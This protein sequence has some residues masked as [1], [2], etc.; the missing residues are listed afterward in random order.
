MLFK[1]IKTF[2]RKITKNLLS[3][4]GAT[5][6]PTSLDSY[7]TKNSGDT[8]SEA[9]INNVQDAIEALETKIGKDSSAIATAI[10]YFLKHVSGNFRIHVHAGGINDGANIPFANITG[11]VRDY[12][13]LKDVKVAATPGGTFTKDTWQQRNINTEEIDTGDN[14]SV[15]SNQITLDAGTYECLIKCPAYRVD[16]H[17]ARLRNITDNST[18]LEG[19]GEF[20]VDSADYVQTSSFIMG[21]F[22][23]AAGKA[24]EIQHYCSTGRANDGLGVPVSFVNEVY[25]I[26]EFRKVA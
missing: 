1:K 12:I 8:I 11:F 3:E 17:K 13:L 18:T 21:R 4:V 15:A 7:S 6:F 24:F 19:T 16:N 26:A 25:T 14:C 2:I 9:H 23:I 10:D 22:T 5:N 20:T